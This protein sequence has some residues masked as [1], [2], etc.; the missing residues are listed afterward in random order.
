MVFSGN[1]WSCVKEVKPLVVFD[2]DCCMALEPMQGIGPHLDLI[3]GTRSSFVLLRGLQGPSRLVTVFLGTLWSSIKEVRA[4]F[5]FDVEHGIAQH[6][7]QLNRGS[8]RSEGSSL[9]VFLELQWD[10]GVYC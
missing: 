2:K 1:L 9:M 8:S 10:P 7:M 3:C 5:V 6:A 4:P